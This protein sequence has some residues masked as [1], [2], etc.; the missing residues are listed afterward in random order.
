MKKFKYGP[1]AFIFVMCSLGLSSLARSDAIACGAFFNDLDRMKHGNEKSPI[2]GFGGISKE[3]S[4][5]LYLF[6]S[7][8]ISC[9]N[10]IR[11]MF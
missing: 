6:S 1:S 10:I 8:S 11:V 9:L 7:F 3:F 2:S 4:S 5:I